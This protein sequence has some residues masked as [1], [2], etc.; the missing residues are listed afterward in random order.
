MCG[1]CS[2]PEKKGHWADSGLTS[3][4]DRVLSRLNRAKK[5]NRLL[6]NYKLGFHDD[7]VSRG[8]QISDLTGKTEVVLN[9]DELWAFAE[10]FLGKTVDPLEK[11]FDL[12]YY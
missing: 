1:G 12:K 7:G 6:S 8:A 2:L 9:I 5:L 10:L 4:R 11:K 3:P